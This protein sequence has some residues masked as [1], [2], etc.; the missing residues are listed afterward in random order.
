MQ[1]LL[2]NVNDE[3]ANLIR[4]LSLKK[5]QKIDAL[6]RSQ[7]ASVMD[8]HTANLVLIANFASRMVNLSS[9]LLSKDEL[10]V[11]EYG[12]KFA[13]PPPLPLQ[14]TATESN[15]YRRYYCHSWE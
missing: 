13:V 2:V 14:S 12:P 11:L 4:A 7:N 9:T 8:N 10:A 1:I 5:Y 6:L 3:E 15:G